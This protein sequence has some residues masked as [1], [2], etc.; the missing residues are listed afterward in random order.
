MTSSVLITELQMHGGKDI[1][2]SF[3]CSLFLFV[4]LHLNANSHRTDFYCFQTGFPNIFFFGFFSWN[5]YVLR[6]P[7]ISLM[8]VHVPKLQIIF[9]Y[10]LYICL[11][12]NFRPLTSSQS[13]TYRW[14]AHISDI[15][16]PGDPHLLGAHVINCRALI[17]SL[18]IRGSGGWEV[19]WETCW[20]EEWHLI[21]TNH[22][23][24]LIFLLI[25]GR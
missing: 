13:H 4:V 21:W 14:W 19:T 12:H 18:S 24:A 7:V 8:Y 6:Y 25:H 16:C 20:V 2:L 9:I 1:S 5:E 15:R 10:L 17:N 3:Y 11:L 22:V 23:S